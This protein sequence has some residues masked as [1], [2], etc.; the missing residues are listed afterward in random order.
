MQLVFTLEL[1]A[2]FSWGSALLKLGSHLVVSECCACQIFWGDFMQTLKRRQRMRDTVQQLMRS[3]NILIA[4][5]C[6]LLVRQLWRVLKTITKDLY[7]LEKNANHTKHC[8]CFDVLSQVID[9]NR[10]FISVPLM[11]RHIRYETFKTSLYLN[12]LF[13]N[14]SIYRSEDIEDLLDECSRIQEPQ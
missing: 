14:F 1:D 5:C 9:F 2:C 12:S 13:S 3:S 6:K 8:F 4:M 7:Q 11:R 10:S